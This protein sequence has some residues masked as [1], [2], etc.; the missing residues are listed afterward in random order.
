M[1]VSQ[2]LN[3]TPQT[4]CVTLLRMNPEPANL[5]DYQPRHRNEQTTALWRTIIFYGLGILGL[6]VVLGAIFLVALW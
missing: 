4:N 2:E 5:L 6:L 3:A 1:H